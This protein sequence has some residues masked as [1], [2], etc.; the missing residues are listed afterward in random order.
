MMPQPG[1]VEENVAGVNLRA[2]LT[3][4]NQRI[5][6][7]LDRDHQLGHSYLMDLEDAEALRFA[8][9][10]RIVPLLQE[11]FYNDDRRLCVVLGK[12][13][14]E[15]RTDQ[16]IPDDDASKMLDTE[17]ER[18]ELRR[19]ENDDAAFLDALRQLYG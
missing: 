13:F 2:L 7:L 8:W 5:T 16:V 6:A 10:H 3:R 11:Y 19:F 15:K 9:Y 1:L 18:F 4:L 17:T 14:L 12:A